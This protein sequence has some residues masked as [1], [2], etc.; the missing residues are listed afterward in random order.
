MMKDHREFLSSMRTGGDFSPRL[1]VFVEEYRSFRNQA[2]RPL[3]ILDIGC[4]YTPQ[5]IHHIIEG[6]TYYCCDYHEEI[7]AET[8][9]YSKIDLNSDRLDEVFEGMRFDVVFCGE[10]IE[11][12]YSPDDL[13]AEMREILE[14]DGILILSTPNLAYLPNRLLLLFGISPI[15]LENSSERQLGRRLKVLGQGN[16]TKGHIR[17]FTYRAIRDLLEL[18]G[19][20]TLRVTAVPFQ[21]MWLDRII[22]RI[23]RSLAP[24]NVFTLQR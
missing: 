11:H 12:L 22:C 9:R 20:R 5:L 6:D 21:V 8:E 2:G 4:S 1:A 10:V 16:P 18:K 7:D 17:V 19:F 3:T 13:L 24:I 14:P 15:F 23:S